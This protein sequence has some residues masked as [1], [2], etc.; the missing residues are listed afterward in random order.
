MRTVVALL[1]FALILPT[2]AAA[3]RRSVR[4]DLPVDRVD[5]F[6]F[7]STHTV[8]AAESNTVGV[9]IAAFTTQVGGTLEA[10]V[11]RVFRDATTALLARVVGV[12]WSVMRD[13]R[14]HVLD[15][16]KI[17]GRSVSLRVD[18]GG[19]LL[20]GVGWSEFAGAG[21]GFDAF[22][23]VFL[24]AR[25]PLPMEWPNERPSGRFLR[26]RLTIDAFTDRDTEWQLRY[27]RAP[28]PADC[29]RCRAIRY[30]GTAV[31][32]A[33][34]RHPARGGRLE[35]E[36]TVEGLL[37]FEPGSTR[38]RSHHWSQRWDRR[39]SAGVGDEDA[40]GP[41]VATGASRGTVRQQE[42]IEGSLIREA[43]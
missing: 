8:D 17:E 18:D 30:H 21:G 11:P 37:I 13:G 16:A 41:G 31:E 42:R 10:R 26:Q 12:R 9:E 19:A 43:R 36:G 5:H 23:D 1:L 29:G 40:G 6:R 22:A 7:Q 20:D 33:V 25:W 2:A 27:E 28:A 38:L 4:W 14:E 39:F 15:S 35:G 24:G 3:A 32:V 34:D